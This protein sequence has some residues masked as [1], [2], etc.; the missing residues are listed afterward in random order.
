[1][2]IFKDMKTLFTTYLISLCTLLACVSATT[3]SEKAI[4]RIEPSQE[5][6]LRAPCNRPGARPVIG[7]INLGQGAHPTWVKVQ[8]EEW[9]AAVNKSS[10]VTFHGLKVEKITNWQQLHKA[11]T[12][13]GQRWMAIINPYGEAILA[14][15]KGGW[16]ETLNAVRNYVNNGGS[17]WE[18]GGYSFHQEIFHDGK[19]WQTTVIGPQGMA[20]LGGEV[21]TGP[22]DAAPEKLSVTRTGE[23]WM[24]R[25]FTKILNK[26]LAQVNRAMPLQNAVPVTALIQS[27]DKIY[28]SSYRLGGWGHLWRFGGMNP[29]KSFVTSVVIVAMLHQYTCSP[30]P[31]K[32][33]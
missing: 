29:D 13:G 17:W 12:E 9:V 8:A 20:S 25:P 2:L 11:L 1:M 22:L 24:G 27:K 31:V 7:I 3:A 32:I 33:P 18:T 14:E 23:I 10:L 21:A 6:R 26:Q 19:S 28:V 16:K 4:S 5:E 30:E 15:K